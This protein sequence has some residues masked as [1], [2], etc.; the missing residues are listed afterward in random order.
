MPTELNYNALGARICKAREQV[1]LTQEQL[2]EACSLS[3]AHIGHIE[4]GTRVPSLHTMFRIAVVLRVSIDVLLADSYEDSDKTLYDIETILKNTEKLKLK[5]L[6]G[7]AK[8]LI[9]KIDDKI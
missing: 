8:V 7:A 9:D 3:A 4:R 2:A 5:A 1:R 6:V